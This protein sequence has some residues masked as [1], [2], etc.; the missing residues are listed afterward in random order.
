VNGGAA[1][2]RA[3]GAV[4]GLSR[5]KAAIRGIDRVSLVVI[6]VVMGLMTAIVS[7]QVLLRYAL[8][9]SLDSADELSRLFFVWAMFLAI[10]HGIK[11]GIHVGIDLLVNALPHVFQAVVFRAMSAAGAFLMILVLFVGI[12]AAADKWPELMPTLPVSAGLYYVAVVISAAH[13][14]LHLLALTLGGPRTWEDAPA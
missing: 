12:D 1:Q 4:P 2:T 14:F 11:V 10:P 6:V 8:D 13:S 9:S 7:V 5:L 3:N